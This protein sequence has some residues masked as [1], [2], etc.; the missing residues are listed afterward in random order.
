MCL[1]AFLLA[2]PQI[3]ITIP[4]AALGATISI[5]T[6]KVGPRVCKV[7]ERVP[8]PQSGSSP[9]LS[10]SL[11]HASLGWLPVA[12]PCH[13]PGLM[14]S[15]GQGEVD[16]KVPSGSQ[17]GDQLLMRGRGIKKLNSTAFGNQ[18]VHLNVAVPK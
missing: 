12:L 15:C 18:Y 13:A 16:L 1:L 10:P 8:V 3:P 14:A 9:P 4:Q 7:S 5:P 11:T 2:L 17:P 6:L